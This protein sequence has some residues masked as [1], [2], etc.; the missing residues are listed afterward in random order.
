LT[1]KATYSMTC[2]EAIARRGRAG[3][4]AIQLEQHAN[5]KSNLSEDKVLSEERK[6]L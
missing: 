2:G 5:P 1:I 4:V 3:D 6:V